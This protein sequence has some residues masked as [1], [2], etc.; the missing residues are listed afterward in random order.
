MAQLYCSGPVDVWFGIGGSISSPTPVFIGHG[1]S[2]PRIREVSNFK[3]VT[4]DIG[5]DME[6]IDKLF[7]R[8]HVEGTVDF[9]RYNVTPLMQ[10]LGRPNPFA[11]VRGTVPPLG[12]GSLMLT[13]GLAFQIWLRWPYSAKAAMAGLP[14]GI[15]LIA[16]VL[17]GPDDYELGVDN[18]LKIQVGFYGLSVYDPVGKGFN[19]YDGNM[20]ALGAIN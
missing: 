14:N 11:G 4:S 9:N 17:T 19:I 1:E 7:L 2:A 18:P 13:E 16:G 6:P 12:V 8:G 20:T 15:R 10:A 5:G 3:D